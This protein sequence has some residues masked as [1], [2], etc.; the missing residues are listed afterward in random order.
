MQRGRLLIGLFCLFYC[1]SCSNVRNGQYSIH[2]KYPVPALKEDAQ[3]LEKILESNH[4]S[5]YWY[6]PKEQMDIY[7]AETIQGIKDSLT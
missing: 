4:P 2:Q 3:I 6:T 7:F 5:L 1:C